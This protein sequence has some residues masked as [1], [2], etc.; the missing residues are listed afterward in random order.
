MSLNA[1]ILKHPSLPFDVIVRNGDALIRYKQSQSLEPANPQ[2]V[3]MA[4]LIKELTSPQ[5]PQTTPTE[6]TPEIT[7]KAT[8]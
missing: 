4:F 8:K 5:S 6:V 3:L 2:V 7:P 1:E